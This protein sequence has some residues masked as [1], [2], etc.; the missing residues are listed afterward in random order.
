VG[1]ARN[2]SEEPPSN[3]GPHYPIE[4][5]DNALRLLMA[6]AERKQVRVSEAA[7]ELGT[8]VSTAHR[9]L[10]MLAHHDLAVQD[11]ETKAYRAGPTLLRIGLA[12]VKN[13][14]LRVLARPHIE[15]LR[16][17]AGETVHLAVL[18]GR[19]VL[20]VDCAESPQALRVASRI[21][22]VMP[23]HC[24]SVGKA[25]LATLSEPAL[26]SLY[27]SARVTPLTAYS[28][29]QR[30]ELLSQLE[31]TR[32]VGYARNR[33]ESELGVGSVSAAV[34]DS[35]GRAVAGISIAVPLVRMADDRWEE[36]AA[37]VVSAAKA[38]ED[39]LP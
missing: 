11:S 5:V 26:R 31:E 38:V 34:R 12:A 30:S 2:P 23:A 6:V 16:D 20:F 21:G 27:R 8:A 9:L 37:D 1:P 13:F 19:D 10:A 3:R 28:I 15:S 36:L 29:T 22:T 17:A 35:R 25:L 39:V 24:T 7:A 14:D 4:S 18:Q 32:T 33:N